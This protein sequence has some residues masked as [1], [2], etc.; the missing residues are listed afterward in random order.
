MQSSPKAEPATASAARTTVTTAA[1]RYLMFPPIEDVNAA[2]HT[3]RPTASNTR[4]WSRLY[5]Q[6][7]SRC[8]IEAARSLRPAVAVSHLCRRRADAPTPALP[9]VARG[10]I[11]RDYTRSRPALDDDLRSS[12]FFAIA[13]RALETA[14]GLRPIRLAREP[15]RARSGA[16]RG[17]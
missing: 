13:G 3:K 8:P 6:S 10:R 16:R 4:R 15:R 14:K 12:T 7:S 11:G 5:V 17:R 1:K 9:G 2:D